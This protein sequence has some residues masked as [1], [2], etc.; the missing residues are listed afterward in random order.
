MTSIQ[1]QAEDNRR[2][3]KNEWARLDYKRNPAKHLAKSRAWYAASPVRAY[4]A[5]RAY[6]IRNPKSDM[7]ACKKAQAKRKNI[8]FN[9]SFEEI[10]WPDVCPVLGMPLI[11]QRG[12]GTKRRPYDDSPSFDRINP[13]LGYVK[14]NVQILSNRANRIKCDATPHELF[15]LS[16]F[17]NGTYQ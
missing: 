3:Y 14:G 9:I 15:L 2:D 12:R 7:Y 16:N 17:V 11:Y 13:N 10:I 6:K 1:K 8:E 4:M 5:A